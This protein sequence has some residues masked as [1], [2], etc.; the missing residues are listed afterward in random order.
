M[1]REDNICK[2]SDTTDY[3]NNETWCT[4][5]KKTVKKIES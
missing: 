1:L 2:D 5:I 4:K 3:K